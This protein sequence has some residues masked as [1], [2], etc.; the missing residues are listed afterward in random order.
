MITF[1]RGSVLFTREVWWQIGGPGII[2]VLISPIVFWILYWVA[3][4]TRYPYLPTADRSEF[5]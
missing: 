4:A 1:R 5:E 3:R 2:A